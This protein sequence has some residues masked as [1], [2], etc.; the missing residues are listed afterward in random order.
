M[1]TD[2]RLKAFVST[3]QPDKARLFYINILGLKLLSEDHF[4]LE[5]ESNMAIFFRYRISFYMV[6]S[7]AKFLDLNIVVKLKIFMQL[8]CFLSY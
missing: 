2:N 4:G 3:T 5:C 6:G 7:V 1:L 8:R